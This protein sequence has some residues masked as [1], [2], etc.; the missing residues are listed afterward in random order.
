[1]KRDRIGKTIEAVKSLYGNNEKTKIQA[2]Y[3]D[4]NDNDYV[5]FFK[6]PKKHYDDYRR[7]YVTHIHTEYVTMN[8]RYVWGLR[9]GYFCTPREEMK[10]LEKAGHYVRIY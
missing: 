3:K 9:V 6:T 2:I 7:K 4:T 5:V 8:N 10:H 1:M